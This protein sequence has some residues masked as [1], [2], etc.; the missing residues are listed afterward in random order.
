MIASLRPVSLLLPVL[1]LSGGCFSIHGSLNND[2]RVIASHALGQS[3]Q[4]QHDLLVVKIKNLRNY[5]LEGFPREASAFDTAN[6]EM[7]GFLPKGTRLR[8]RDVEQTTFYPLEAH[9]YSA[10][11]YVEQ[12]C[13]LGSMPI[14]LGWSWS[15]P[16][17]KDPRLA[18]LA[19]TK[20]VV[21][22]DQR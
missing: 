18:P 17:V 11:G 2:P 6:E 3:W 20:R 9:R 8:I 19:E 16:A 4:V 1:L 5:H 21:E 14:E 22:G 7:V 10:L 12:G 15:P 13:G